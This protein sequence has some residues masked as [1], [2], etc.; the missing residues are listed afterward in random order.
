VPAHILAGTASQLEGF[1]IGSTYRE[2]QPAVRQQF[3]PL[4][5]QW[6]REVDR[7]LSHATAQDWQEL[8]KNSN[9]M[10]KRY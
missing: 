8:T 4:Q 6:S 10:Q 7:M 2:H 1:H 3:D 5:Q 9:A